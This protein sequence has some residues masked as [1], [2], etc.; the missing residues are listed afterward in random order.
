M[1]EKNKVRKTFK[2]GRVS[3]SRRK[4]EKA[5][6][7]RWQSSR[8]KTKGTRAYRDKETCIKREGKQP[9]FCHDRDSF[10]CKIWSGNQKGE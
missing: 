10:L 3:K 2:K 7:N 1:V 4:E 5:D 9:K 8:E 6:V